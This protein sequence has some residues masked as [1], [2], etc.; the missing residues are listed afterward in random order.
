MC[1]RAAAKALGY[2]K[3]ER[4]VPYLEKAIKDSEA[5]EDAHIEVGV[6][7]KPMLSANYK[8]VKKHSLHYISL[9]EKNM[10]IREKLVVLML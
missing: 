7:E 1:G 2:K 5:I 8:F 10:I 4:A 9:Q 3:I 6:T